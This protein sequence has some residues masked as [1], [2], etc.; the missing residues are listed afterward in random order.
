MKPWLGAFGLALLAACG[1]APDSEEAEIALAEANAE[2]AAT[3]AAA[4]PSA[5]ARP[6]IGWVQADGPGE[7]AI[8]WRLD[9]QA[10]GFMLSCAQEGA[11]FRISLPDPAG[12]PTASGATGTLFLGGSGFPLT[13]LA[14]DV[15]G[16]HLDGEMRVTPELLDSLGQAQ[17]VRLQVGDSFS[18]TGADP[19]RKLAELAA[20]CAALTGV[21][22]QPTP[23]VEPG[24]TDEPVQSE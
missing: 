8:E 4:A 11:L 19:E 24:T 3:E 7:T 5:P 6:T 2:R 15:A 21:P 16:P 17:T 9:P 18:E 23:V 20:S 1:P 12:I 14:G 10:P 22:Y 13:L